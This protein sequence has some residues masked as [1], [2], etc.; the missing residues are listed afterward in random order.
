MLILMLWPTHWRLLEILLCSISCQK[1][2][3]Y[4]WV[5]YHMDAGME[6]FCTIWT[7]HMVSGLFYTQNQC[8]V[9]VFLAALHV[10]PVMLQQNFLFGRILLIYICYTDITIAQGERVFGLFVSFVFNCTVIHQE[11]SQ[12]CETLPWNKMLVS[13]VPQ[14]YC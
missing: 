13:K 6:F 9:E 5:A 8:H 7:I 1:D 10:G 3:E 12:I 2:S 4:E 11:S 14:D